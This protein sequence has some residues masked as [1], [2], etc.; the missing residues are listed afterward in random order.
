MMRKPPKAPAA[1]HQATSNR[2]RADVVADRRKAARNRAPR[3][4]GTANSDR[5]ADPTQSATDSGVRRQSPEYLRRVAI[6]E[7]GGVRTSIRVCIPREIAV[8]FPDERPSLAWLVAPESEWRHL[9]GEASAAHRHAPGAVAA[10]RGMPPA[11]VAHELAEAIGDRVVY[12]RNW[13][14]ARDWVAALYSTIGMTNPPFEVHNLDSLVESQG[15]LSTECL[16]AAVVAHDT[17]RSLPRAATEATW[18]AEFLLALRRRV[19]DRTGKWPPAPRAKDH[20]SRPTRSSPAR[21]REP[22]S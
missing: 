10:G 13:T 2:P 11:L 5:K 17:V 8:A 7:I 12:A 15:A 19:Q 4:S 6:L 21:K 9:A 3:K 1:P 18:Y 14:L 16:G 22:R 20:G